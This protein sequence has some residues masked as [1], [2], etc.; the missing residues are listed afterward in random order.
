MAVS[1]LLF[2]FY[3]LMHMY[4]NLKAFAGRSSFDEYAEH[5]RELLMPILP[6]GGFLWIFRVVLIVA[7]IAH[8]WAATTLWR[9]ANHA[10]GSRYAVKK[11]VA[12]TISSSW[13]RW[14]GVALLLFI[15]FH[16]LQFTTS[17]IQVDGVYYAS[18]YE[19]MVAGFSAWWVVVVY[20]LAL[21]ALA[22]HL[23]H[24]IWS[25]CQTLGLVRSQRSTRAVNTVAVLL[26][27]VVSI[28]FALVPL[29]VLFGIIN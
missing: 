13:M 11:R 28:G 27:A 22:M 7:V 19:R 6:Y 10:R 14:G 25:A 20:L 24:G 17:T 21:V 8:V 15:I 23:R 9:R 26:A 12:A 29:A 2:V 5:L 3:V 1:G 18:P 16:L 4:G